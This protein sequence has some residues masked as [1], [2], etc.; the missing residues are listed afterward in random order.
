MSAWTPLLVLTLAIAPQEQEKKVPADSVEIA[1]SGCLKGRVFTATG[2]REGE[3]IS[4]GPNVIGRSFRLAGPREVM[5]VV[6]KHDGHYVEVI[7]LV[8]K[9]ALADNAPG[10][11]IGNTRVVIGG[12]PQRSDP[13]SMQARSMPQGGSVVMD[14]SAVR[15]LSDTC[16]IARQ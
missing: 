4:R 1:S 13:T 7:G 16:P 8:R 10:A 11:R 15:Y 12:N 6:K 2:Q 14:A 9:S 3:N 5:D